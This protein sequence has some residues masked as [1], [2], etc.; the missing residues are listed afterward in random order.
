MSIG[1]YVNKARV[2]WHYFIMLIITVIWYIVVCIGRPPFLVRPDTSTYQ[3]TSIKELS[4]SHRLP[5]YQLISLFFYNLCGGYEDANKCIVLF[6]VCIAII[7]SILFYDALYKYLHSRIL[8]LLFG[9]ANMMIIA[10]FGYSE[11]LLTESLAVSI[12]CI[13]IWILIQAVSTRRTKYFIWLSIIS[14]YGTMIRPSFIFLFP[15]L[16][17]FFVCFYIAD[18]RK[19]AFT[20]FISLLFAIFVIL[21]YCKHNELLIGKF[22]LSDVS[23]NNDL[24]SIIEGEMYNNPDYLEITEFIKT[25]L[26]NDDTN[27]LRKAK[28]TLNYFGYDIGAEYI[29]D[30]KKLHRE[31]YINYVKNNALNTLNQPVVK[32]H[33]QLASEISTRRQFIYEMLGITLLPW[34]FSVLLLLSI[35][36]L[37]YVI[38][39]SIKEKIFYYVDFGIVACI[40]C[41]YIL[42]LITLYGAALQ[43]I[44]IHIIPCA[45]FLESLLIKRLFEECSREKV[46]DGSISD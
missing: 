12:M 25:E 23:Y 27:C 37:C 39:R 8:A 43:R 4:W 36:Y 16:A 6:Q 10:I 20:G 30:T 32:L 9:I 1:T 17:I 42:S 24:A 45:G 11:T 15:C 31:Q 21:V 34:S 7:G 13:L 35:I 29:K 2:N 41:I 18:N 33:S 19:L 14:L 26:D 22:C 40:L 28:N 3:I 5:G 38:Y 46:H 44:A